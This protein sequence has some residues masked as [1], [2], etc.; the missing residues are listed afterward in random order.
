MYHA[1][2]HQTMVYA[3]LTHNNLTPLLAEVLI[4]SLILWPTDGHIITVDFKS[5]KPV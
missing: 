4:F 1:K 3:A 2:L 5:C